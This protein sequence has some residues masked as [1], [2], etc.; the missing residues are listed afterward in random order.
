MHVIFSSIL[1][2]IQLLRLS[3]FSLFRLFL[4][5][6]SCF[7]SDFLNLLTS[8]F[9][10]I[11]FH[12]CLL[13]FFISFL[14]FSCLYFFL[15][16]FNYNSFFPVSHLQAHFFALPCIIK[17]ILS[18]FSCLCVISFFDLCLLLYISITLTYVPY[19]S[20]EFTVSF[21]LPYSLSFLSYV[22]TLL[23]LPQNRWETSLP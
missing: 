7:Y 4:F 2:L 21:F 5:S 20:L 1:F 17:Y 8:L 3:S 14:F 15:C 19:T 9:N 22:V 23:F 10:C 11:W 18:S 16:F 12:Y 13:V 6:F